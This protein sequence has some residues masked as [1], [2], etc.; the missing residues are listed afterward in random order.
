MRGLFG[1]VGVLLALAV[2]GMLVRKQLTAVR[3][4]VPVLEAPASATASEPQSTSANAL[5]APGN[6]AQQ[7]QQIQQQIKQAVEGA[8]QARPMPDDK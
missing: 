6:A 1:L 7:S 8:M 2:V 3:V 5:P 4:T